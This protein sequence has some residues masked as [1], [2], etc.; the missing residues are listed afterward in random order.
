MS[1][2]PLQLSGDKTGHLTGH[3]PKTDPKTETHSLRDIDPDVLQRKASQP[4]TSIWVNASAGTGKTKVLTDRVLR[5]LLP[6][7]DGQRGTKAHKILCLTFTKAGASEMAL[8]LQKTLSRWAIAPPETLQGELAGLFGRTPQIHELEAARTLFAE[9]IDTPG[10]LNIMTIHAFCQ[11][12]LGRFPLEARLPPYFTVLEDAAS[13]LLLGEARSNAIAQAQ[14]DK[15]TPLGHAFENIAAIISE[16]QCAAL[17]KTMTGERR[18]MEN[19]LARNFGIEGLYTKLCG[20]LGITAGQSAQDVL[21]ACCRN[22][23]KVG[24]TALAEILGQSKTQTDLANAGQISTWLQSDEM[25]RLENFEAY[26]SVFLTQKDDIRK[27]LL[28]KGIAEAHPQ[29]EEWMQAEALRLAKAAEAAKAANAA[30]LTRDLLVLGQAVLEEYAALKETRSALDFDDLIL[31]TLRLLKGRGDGAITAMSSWVMYKL[32]QGL[33]HILID[34]AQDTN[35]EQWEIIEAL[36]D[37]FFAGQGRTDQTRTVFTVGDEKQSIYSFQRASPNDFRRIQSTFHKKIEEAGERWEKV[38]LNISFRSTQSVLKA[39]D[40]VFSTPAL[41]RGLSETQ[42]AHRAY[43]RKQGGLVELWPLVETGK[44]EDYDLWEPPTRIMEGQN[45]AAALAAKIAARI[46]E[47]IDRKELLESKNRPIRPGDIMILVRTRTALVTH[48][49]RALKALNIPVSGT[50][51]LVV[52]EELA[53]QDLLAMAEFALMPEDDLSLACLLK[54]PLIGMEEE[55]LMDL[56]ATRT[57]SLWAALQTRGNPSHKDITRYLREILARRGS[58]PYDFFAH[59]IQSPC[60][61]DERSGQRAIQ[62]RFGTDSL[63]AL[64]EFLSTTL[65]FE[66]QNIPSLQ[67]FLHLYGRQNVEIKREMEEPKNQVRIMTV[68]G[69]KGLQAP[70]V[71][72]PDTIRISRTSPGHAQER[73]LWPRQTGLAAPIWSP[74]SDMDFETYTALRDTIQGTQDEEYR[75]LLYVA[76]TRAEDRLYVCGHTGKKTPLEDCWYFHIKS[77]LDAFGDIKH[78]GECETLEDGSLRLSNPQTADKPEKSPGLHSESEKPNS[79]DLPLWLLKKAPQ[80]PHPPATLMPSRP[81]QPNAPAASPL[82]RA[83]M[84][85]FRRGNLSHKLLET[86]PDLPEDRRKQAGARFLKTHGADLKESLRAEILEEITKIL[87]HP[88]FA[89]I[90]GPGSRAEVPITGLLSD[91]RIISGQIDRLLVAPQEILIVDYKTNRPPPRQ[92]EDVP[93]IYHDQMRA[94]ADTIREIYPG[95]RVKCALLWTDGPFLM[96]LDV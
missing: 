70:I 55:A 8:R 54:S 86:L 72:M 25:Q 35:P 30:A 14:T 7:E 51:R 94:Y 16:D 85:R 3:D 69:A 48:L 31:T 17:L 83:E 53:V 2:N 56:A 65:D 90:F 88:D 89:G 32:D 46:K 28:G 41:R 12:L 18:Q 1:K 36:C 79:A 63:D 11:S 13:S 10:G 47:W 91:G 34:E 76:M 45:S 57:G 92:S 42:I 20:A 4:K 87:H 27:K 21:A 66:Q 93:Q 39:V 37:E 81:S 43:R 23:D 61:A 49:T 29:A 84:Q 6:R 9:V 44:T 26:K 77:G 96:P 82:E 60:P 62:R 75:R 38:D 22:T 95:R 40:A 15:T 80:E 71:F 58:A 5:L 68:H 19:L 74:R 50:D 59:L 33:D 24:M 78:G 52:N 67:K 64:D 73:F